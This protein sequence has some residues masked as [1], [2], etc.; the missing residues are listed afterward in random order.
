MPSSKIEVF[1]TF[2][3]VVIWVENANAYASLYVVNF[4]L[5]VEVITVSIR[6]SKELRF[7]KV[8]CEFFQ[9]CYVQDFTNIRF[10]LEPYFRTTVNPITT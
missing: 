8:I 5:A 10:L 2:L 1:N 7:N 9:I 4:E 6:L 3:H